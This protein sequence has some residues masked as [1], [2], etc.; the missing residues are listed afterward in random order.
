M[1]VL[2]LQIVFKPA[3]FSLREFQA[4]LTTK[5]REQPVVEACDTKKLGVTCI[6]AFKKME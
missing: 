1:G 2:T 3:A 6:L 5:L 4:T